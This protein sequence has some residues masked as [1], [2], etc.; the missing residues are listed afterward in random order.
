[1]AAFAAN[2]LDA[3]GRAK[4]LDRLLAAAKKGASILV[5][6]PLARRGSPWWPEWE[7]RFVEA[8]GRADEWRFPI[9]L[10]PPLALLDR[11][12][13]LDHRELTA[14][15]IYLRGEVRLGS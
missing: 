15:S 11:A 12:S 8:S 10:P 3:A 6:E 7:K 5:V 2:E 14:R 1:V 9:S 13:G 4:L